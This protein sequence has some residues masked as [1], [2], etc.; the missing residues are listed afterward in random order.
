[1]RGVWHKYCIEMEE[2][3]DVLPP[4]PAH[5]L[6]APS[7]PAPPP[8]SRPPSKTETETET[9]GAT[10][11]AASASSA[12]I[13]NT[14]PSERRAQSDPELV[15]K[16]GKSEEARRGSKM[17]RRVNTLQMLLR[18]SK[19]KMFSTKSRRRTRN[20]SSRSGMSMKDATIRLT[21]TL[22]KNV[23][24]SFTE[25]DI[26]RLLRQRGIDFSDCKDLASLRK[27]MAESVGHNSAASAAAQKRSKN[28]S[29]MLGSSYASTP[30]EKP[31]YALIHDYERE[32]TKPECN[33]FR[34][35]LAKFVAHDV[36][37]DDECRSRVEDAAEWPQR[38]VDGMSRK[39]SHASS[40]DS[41]AS[42]LYHPA[43][44]IRCSVQFIPHDEE[45]AKRASRS[46]A[47]ML[48][49]SAWSSGFLYKRGNTLHKLTAN[50]KKRFFELVKGNLL[51]YYKSKK[52]ENHKGAIDMATVTCIRPSKETGCPQR[53]IDIVTP[54]RTWI[55]APCDDTDYDTW[56]MTLCTLAS[57]GTIDEAL[58]SFIPSDHALSSPAPSAVTLD[59]PSG[60][61][62]SEVVS[63]AF[64]RYK[65]T[66]SHPVPV[67]GVP[68]DYLLKVEGRREFLLVPGAQLESYAHV[69]EQLREGKTPI[70]SLI[71]KKTIPSSR[72][73]ACAREHA[74]LHVP[75]LGAPNRGVKWW[76][77]R[78][79]RY[80]DS[81]DSYEASSAPC[82]ADNV[83]LSATGWPFRAAVISAQ[84]VPA[85]SHQNRQSDLQSSQDE[86][87]TLV[88][89]AHY[90]TSSSIDSRLKSS[91]DTLS[92]HSRDT[93]LSVRI[94][95]V[96]NGNEIPGS[97]LETAHVRSTKVVRANG[98][99]FHASW[100]PDNW[101]TSELW[102]CDLP[103][104]TKVCV[105]MYKFPSTDALACACMQ[106]V[107]FTGVLIAGQLT[108]KLW[109]GNFDMLHTPPGEAADVFGEAEH[110]SVSLRFDEFPY[111]VVHRFDSLV[112]ASDTRTA[113][114]TGCKPNILLQKC[115][116]MFKRGAH[117]YSKWKKRWFVLKESEGTLAYFA[118]KGDSAEAKGVIDLSEASEPKTE[119]QLNM[120]Y[121]TGKG[122]TGKIRSTYCFSVQIASGRKYYISCESERVQQEW[123][124]AVAVVVINFN[125]TDKT[126]FAATRPR[127]SGRFKNIFKRKASSA[128]IAVESAFETA[129]APVR[130]RNSNRVRTNLMAAI[131]A[132]EPTWSD[133]KAYNTEK[134][135]SIKVSTLDI[136][137]QL[138]SFYGT[139]PRTP[140]MSV[141]SAG[142]SRSALRGPGTTPTADMRFSSF[143]HTLFDV[144]MLSFFSRYLATRG[145]STHLKFWL[146]AEWFLIYQATAR[147]E[148]RDE[149]ITQSSLTEESLNEQMMIV[150]YCFG[151][152][153][154][155]KIDI[156]EDIRQELSIAAQRRE[157]GIRL[158]AQAQ[159]E[160]RAQLDKMFESFWLAQSHNI[161]CSWVATRCALH[162]PQT[163]SHLLLAMAHYP[164]LDP[165]YVAQ[166]FCD[167]SFN[168]DVVL[169][170]LKD[171]SDHSL[172]PL[173][174][175]FVANPRQGL[176]GNAS[177][178]LED[179]SN[180]EL[181]EIWF[182]KV[183]G[184][185]FKCF[186]MSDI[187]ADLAPKP[188]LYMVHVN[189]KPSL[190]D[191]HAVVYGKGVSRVLP[192]VPRVNASQKVEEVPNVSNRLKGMIKNNLGRIIS[193]G[194]LRV[195]TM[196]FD[197]EDEEES[198]DAV[199]MN[200]A[201]EGGG[202]RALPQVRAGVLQR[203]VRK[204]SSG[205]YSQGSISRERRSIE[206]SLVLD[207]LEIESLE[208]GP[209]T[210]S[211]S[212]DDS[213]D[214]TATSK[215]SASPRRARRH[216]MAMSM[217]T[218]A[219]D[220]PALTT[221]LARDPLYKLK[222]ADK[223]LLW[224][225]R[226]H[227]ME[228]HGFNAAGKLVRAVDWKNGAQV[229]ECYRLMDL[230]KT[231]EEPALV[232]EL[233]GSYVSDTLIRDRS[234]ALLRSM[235]DDQL[236]N[237]MPQLVQ[238]LKYEPYHDS[239]LA[240]FLLERAFLSPLA[241]GV[242]L[243]WA[244]KVELHQERFRERY[245]LYLSELLRYS[246]NSFCAMIQVQENL[247][248]ETGIF[249]KICLRVQAL[250]KTTP[251]SRLN[252]VL[253]QELRSIDHILVSKKSIPLPLNPYWR[254][255]GLVVNKCKVMSSAKKPL[256]LVFHNAEGDDVVMVMF[257]AGDDLR[258]DIVTLQ[259]LKMCH[260]VWLGHSLDLKVTPY[261]CISLWND[262]GMLEIVRN[263]A[264]TAFIHKLYGG[265]MG[266]FL[267]DTISKFLRDHNPDG[268][269]NA[270]NLFVRSCAGYCVF[271]YMLGIGDRHNDNIMIT[272]K[273]ALFHIDFGHFLGNV[274]YFLGVK[275]ERSAFV[276]TPE[277]AHVMGGVKGA[278]FREFESTCCSALNM[279]R[280][281]SDAF[282]LLFAL[283]IPGGMPELSSHDDIHYFTEM[284]NRSDS[285]E[286][287]SA[288]FKHEIKRSLKN[289]FR[290]V[291]NT[292]H[293]LKHG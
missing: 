231:P 242:S 185:G 111:P 292:L 87:S 83:E 1:M 5:R 17:R 19:N 174:K 59:A 228:K 52:R 88:R 24:K 269:D 137:A 58:S 222:R 221:L 172:T 261:R 113:S 280:A 116:W 239:A 7:F 164:S 36:F 112:S 121:K 200:E 23:R 106:L 8:P 77:R 150:I 279:I 108:L 31:V 35:S 158:M 287:A 62:V 282:V 95:L 53:A 169:Q 202:I 166:C 229:A 180:P 14:E 161:E 271:T 143:V 120:K 73:E 40:V 42:S 286:A 270:V 255:G 145:Y 78:A 126:E 99:R 209:E 251:K 252:D 291:D 129:R 72:L 181:E 244:F 267:D 182:E 26:K 201:E 157:N 74:R 46:R 190:M 103:P 204:R 191:K 146:K 227:L 9:E 215:A 263:S 15:V 273:G 89:H 235:N 250:A 80:T 167:L 125:C 138:D 134:K 212:E 21:E 147:L 177:Q 122:S 156:S 123:M 44:I 247:F 192:F 178:R 260:S 236:V 199:K 30:P 276:F 75:S 84:Y 4:P 97:R 268:Y 162:S 226:R 94:W 243:Y 142:S 93:N 12:A 86:N 240:R 284:A 132:M 2:E 153:V 71:E 206:T 41:S 140:N 154:R 237:I 241:I 81:R 67:S 109:H 96:H 38:L 60:A 214:E 265:K 34:E 55:L 76:H 56:M 220:L 135:L 39:K 136:N 130:R 188:N 245:C 6:P 293:I 168:V 18:T 82:A 266:A 45:E 207:N 272:E 115:G 165:E 223:T 218:L 48:P 203:L 29:N 283:M 159:E 114:I 22:Q 225:Y 213:P 20:A 127:A 10:A 175:R 160:V 194:K 133:E 107:D 57:P 50:Y 27:R 277:M 131:N 197:S 170:W 11:S 290:Q 230:W 85:S 98:E 195:P 32:S 189:S 117:S 102:Y 13:S 274:K 141:S 3:A 232:L 69:V 224:K 43:S 92:R 155:P 163:V 119:N 254:V 151:P 198:P 148:G 211:D 205:A 25:E 179:G 288:K 234:V 193:M 176:A 217:E 184:A 70:F 51:A 264:T 233:L 33:A 110:S 262:G 66:T 104:S 257:K 49:V 101:L 128:S 61:T 37:P 118:S 208:D 105:G 144:K 64:A 259:M 186:S 47:D 238:A 149:D 246:I 258:Q 275:R 210:G 285:D 65:R 219:Q 256:W 196:R 54:A 248:S 187:V 183:L 152:N 68:S 16:D 289:I 91:S 253:R 173:Q 249:A 79:G 63:Q 171:A 281:V 216:S 28:L 139:V 100:S 124:T 278:M 90:D